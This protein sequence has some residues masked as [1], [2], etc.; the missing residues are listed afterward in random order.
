MKKRILVQGATGMLGKPA[1]QQLSAAGFQV[2]VLT[3]DIEKAKSQ[4][5]ENW[6][7]VKGDVTDP[8]ALEKSM[9]DCQGVHISIGGDNDQISAELSVEAAV[10]Q[11]VEQ[12]S[13]ISGATVC[14]E[15][16]W[17]PMV[18]QKL[19]AEKALRGCG[20]PYTIFCPTWP[21]EQLPRFA[22]G[23]NPSLMG[24]QPNL[25]HWFA[26]KDLGIMI[27]N[28]YQSTAAR[29]KR[30]TVFGPQALTMKT[31]L[32]QY[33]TYFH[34]EVEKISVMPIWTAKLLGAVTGN[35]MLKF[36]SGLMGYFNKTA[37]TGSPEEAN[38]ILENPKTTLQEWMQE[39]S[40]K[41]KALG[42]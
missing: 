42:K 39:L 8:V 33:C 9:Q 17:F 26:A 10:K 32:Q 11:G 29:N 25:I 38:Q 16:R 19:N 21:M 5:P 2:R 20:I 15:N 40:Q 3:R 14:E 37:E 13:Y 35:E 36:A 34:P 31:A 41:E 7:F 24:Q 12:I 1:A 28:A 23:G 27:A 30:F 4:L 6:E 18:G 22:R